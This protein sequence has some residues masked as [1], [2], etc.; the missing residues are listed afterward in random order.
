MFDQVMTRHFHEIF[1]DEMGLGT[2]C[3]LARAGA[4]PW[5][6]RIEAEGPPRCSRS[7][8]RPGAMLGRALLGWAGLGWAR[9]GAGVRQ[10]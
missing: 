9:L 7:R 6:G 3:S 2:L 4:R 1:D 8:R 10:R 5:L